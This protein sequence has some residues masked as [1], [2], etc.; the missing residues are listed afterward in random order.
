MV[1][2]FDETPERI[3]EA[4]MELAARHAVANGAQALFLLGSTG[5]GPW[6]HE[7]VERL[8]RFVKVVPD[9]VPREV[10]VLV[11]AF[12]RERS[13]ERYRER[14][15]VLESTTRI[16][17]VVLAPPLDFLLEPN[18]LKTFLTEVASS[19][20]LPVFFYNNPGAFAGNQIDPAWIGEREWG[21]LD[22]LVGL[23]D[24]SDSLQYKL[25]ALE[26]WAATG[27]NVYSGK[28]GTFG[29]LLLE[30]SPRLRKFAG[31]VPSIGNLSRLPR[32]LAEAA[33]DRVVET[34]DEELNAWRNR[35]YDL[36][37]PACKAQRGLK[38]A[39]EEAYG[40][41]RVGRQP[42]VTCR[43]LKPP[44]EEF[45]GS[46]REALARWRRLGHVRLVGGD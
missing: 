10:P 21:A 39:F 43:T 12:S 9:L 28:E 23:K 40:S 36:S 46:L 5:E 33:S 31:V 15:R 30:T 38:V 16:D 34:L 35:F 24:S 27:R 8:K 13:P 19:T 17:G 32:A 42:V 22:H 45:R 25:D 26:L 4:G 18:E 11:G 37:E 2:L 29:R 44:S 3:H 1:T 6:F 7:R 20:S 41:E 14:L